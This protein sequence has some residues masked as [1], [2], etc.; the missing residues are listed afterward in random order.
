METQVLVTGGNGQL[1]QTI[2]ALYFKNEDDIQ[3]TFLNK[4]ALDI[5]NLEA[6]AAFFTTRNFDYCINCAAYTNVE[7]AET[8]ITLAFKIKHILNDLNLNSNTIIALIFMLLVILF[9]GFLFAI[10]NG[11]VVDIIF[12]NK[13]YQAGF[14]ILFLLRKH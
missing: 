4:A 7:Q 9:I 6:V 1:A 10:T 3:F 11:Q 13:L 8:A 12:G 14:I 5:T 2:K